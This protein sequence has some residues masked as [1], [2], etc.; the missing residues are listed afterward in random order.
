MSN[1]TQA[2]RL[3]TIEALLKNLVERQEEDRQNS[4]LA[5]DHA[6]ESR[7]EVKEELGRLAREQK[8]MNDW[9]IKKADPFIDMGTSLK[10]KA[11]GGFLALGIIGGIAWTGVKFFKEQIVGFFGG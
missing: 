11:T 3:A 2:E 7:A 4:K 9:R 8:V 6:D 5:N 1:R 10:A